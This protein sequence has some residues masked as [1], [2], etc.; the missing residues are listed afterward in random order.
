MLGSSSGNTFI[1]LARNTAHKNALGA[2]LHSGIARGHSQNPASSLHVYQVYGVPVLLS[3]LGPLVFYKSEL[4]LVSQHHREINSNLQRLLPA[5]A[6]SVIYFLAGS[7]PG[8]ALLHLRQLSIF[9]MISCLKNS[10]SHQV[11]STLLSSN[12][13]PAKSWI[14]Q[15]WEHCL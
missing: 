12:V 7:L 5:T 9:G 15:S 4:S 14:F 8:E 3:G 6:G 2:V 11:A 10:L 1:I 13:V